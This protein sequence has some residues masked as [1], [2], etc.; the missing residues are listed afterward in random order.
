MTRTEQ[1]IKITNWFG[2]KEKLMP[3]TKFNKRTTINTGNVDKNDS[4]NFKSDLKSILRYYRQKL[5]VHATLRTLFCLAD[6]VILRK[7][8]QTRKALGI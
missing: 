4:F 7:V 1:I 3:G 6:N 8:V 2:F 5:K